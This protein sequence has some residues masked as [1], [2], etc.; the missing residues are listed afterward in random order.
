[1]PISDMIRALKD[2]TFRGALVN[3]SEVFNPA[4]IPGSN[5]GDSMTLKMA[6]G[7]RGGRG[8]TPDSYWPLCR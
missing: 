8:G 7:V 2:P 5:T 6:T 4:R 1:M 3:N